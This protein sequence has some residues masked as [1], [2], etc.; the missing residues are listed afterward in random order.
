MKCN[1][2]NY[3]WINFA[4]GDT[5]YMTVSTCYQAYTPH[6]I[7]F[8][9]KYPFA[10]NSPE[11]QR[12]K[13]YMHCPQYLNSFTWLLAFVVS[14]NDWFSSMVDLVSSATIV[15]SIKTFVFSSALYSWSVFSTMLLASLLY[16]ACKF[17]IA[18]ITFRVSVVLGSLWF[19]FWLVL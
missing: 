19:N 6:T 4:E 11:I 16:E 18:C 10:F 13:T 7:M 17:F 2:V 12:H 5:Q 1:A 14:L 15:K 3:W 9:F 8:N